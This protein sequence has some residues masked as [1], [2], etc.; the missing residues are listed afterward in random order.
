MAKQPSWGR[1]RR[2]GAT[3][4]ESE[5]LADVLTHLLYNMPMPV[6]IFDVT[7][8]TVYDNIE[9]SRLLSIQEGK[10]LSVE[11]FPLSIQGVLKEGITQCLNTNAA[12]TH[13]VWVDTQTR[14]RRF[15]RH[16]FIPLPNRMVACTMIDLTDL[17]QTEEALR[18][19]E[20]KFRE[21]VE[22]MGEGFAI[23]DRE[24]NF[25]FA[26][27]AAELIFGT[28]RGELVGA[29][30]T[31][32]TAPDQVDVLKRQAR[33]RQSGLAAA[34]EVEIT[35]PDGDKRVVT[36][37]STPRFDE[38]GR[39]LGSFGPIRDVTELKKAEEALRENESF[40]MGILSSLQ[41]T[42]IIV[43]DINGTHIAI[44]GDP[45]LDEKYQIDSNTLLGQSLADVLPETEA[46]YRISQ[47]RQVCEAGTPLH[48]EYRARLLTPPVSVP[49]QQQAR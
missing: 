33:R 13:E 17:M 19:S 5:Q 18:R 42:I 38:H 2:F 24:E 27:P 16:T 22:N 35:R 8:R 43:Y 26:N 32:F 36:S 28:N 41:E 3:I 23:L 44:W 11:S 14:G 15:L 48:E 46:R 10:N 39:Y 31:A 9:G 34:F 21:L 37:T 4:S 49:N 6:W 7:L 12:R 1:V 30:F 25:V 40:L 47:I 29:N 20:R 45:K